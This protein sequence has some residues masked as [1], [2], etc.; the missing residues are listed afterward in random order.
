M[1]IKFKKLKML[2]DSQKDAI[3]QV[4]AQTKD[5]DLT[6]SDFLKLV[7]EYIFMKIAKKQ[8]IKELTQ[9]NQKI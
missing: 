1:K 3:E 6:T 4:I 7:D 8:I 5:E 2:S 9:E